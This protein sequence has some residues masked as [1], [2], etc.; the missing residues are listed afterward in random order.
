MTSIRKAPELVGRAA[1]TFGAALLAVL[2]PKCPLCIAAY[3][4]A[5]GLSAVAAQSA[6]PFVRPIAFTL[7]AGTLVALAFGVWRRRA[8]RALPS[9][10]SR[11]RNYGPTSTQPFT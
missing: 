6:A 8:R 10:C 5:A 7:L 1:S 4:S 2:L 3:L 9:C 11:L